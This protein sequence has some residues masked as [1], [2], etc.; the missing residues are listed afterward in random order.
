MI[1][2]QKKQKAHKIPILWNE[3][4]FEIVKTWKYLGLT[5][6]RLPNKNDHFKKLKTTASVRQAKIIN[7]CS[8]RHLNNYMIHQRIYKSLIKSGF[9]YAM[10]TWAWAT[11]MLKEIEIIQNKYFR[12]LFLLPMTTPAYL[13]QREFNIKPIKHDLVKHTFKFWKKISH[14]KS[15]KHVWEELKYWLRR[16][17]EKHNPL[18]NFFKECFPQGENINIDLSELTLEEIVAIEKEALKRI[19]NSHNLTI[20]ESII[21]SWHHSHY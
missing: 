11:S 19:E 15:P 12:R 3:F 20:D 1:F 18:C 6:N 14:N 5:F 17:S 7:L 2:A 4:P 9:V 16:P 10:P 21:N 8:A 13:L